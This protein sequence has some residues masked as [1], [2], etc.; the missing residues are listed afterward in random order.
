MLTDLPIPD[1]YRVQ[2]DVDD[3]HSETALIFDL[4]ARGFDAA[5][6]EIAATMYR[7]ATDSIPCPDCGGDMYRGVDHY[8]PNECRACG[9]APCDCDV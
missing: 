2:I 1:G 4:D 9:F 7:E 6:I 3:S 8:C 5:A